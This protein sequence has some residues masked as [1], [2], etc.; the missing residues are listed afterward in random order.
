MLF[1]NSN[2][3]PTKKQNKNKNKDLTPPTL[4]PE[5]NKNKKT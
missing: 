5:N 3:S 2:P 1:L 4:P